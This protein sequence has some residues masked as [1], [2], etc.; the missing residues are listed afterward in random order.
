MILLLGA[1]GY[2][3]EAFVK[4]LQRRK[5]EFVA[6][7]RKQTDAATLVRSRHPSRWAGRDDSLNGTFLLLTGLSKRRLEE[8]GCAIYDLAGE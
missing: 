8:E 5:K 7:S 1:S 2:I 3:G 4:E 6:L